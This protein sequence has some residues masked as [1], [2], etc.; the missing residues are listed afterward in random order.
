MM[1]WGAITM[2]GF[3][4]MIFTMAKE[5]L[6]GKME[7]ATWELGK[8]EKDMAMVVCWLKTGALYIKAIGKMVKEMK[9]EFI[10]KKSDFVL[11]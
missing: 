8:M 2:L 5:N 11:I 7:R 4:R 9:P 6:F 10:S 3:L 1:S